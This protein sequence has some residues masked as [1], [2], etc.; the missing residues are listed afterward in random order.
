MESILFVLEVIAFVVVV[1]WTSLVEATGDPTRGVLGM[2]E[3]DVAVPAPAPAET[4]WRSVPRRVTVERVTVQKSKLPRA[5]GPTPAW[6]R[7]MRSDH[8]P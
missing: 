2:R 4:G 1:G 6:R 8:Q 5:V 7:K 3:E